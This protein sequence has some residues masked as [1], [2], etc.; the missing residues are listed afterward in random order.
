MDAVLQKLVLCGCQQVT[1]TCLTHVRDMHGLMYL[2]ITAT[3]IG[4]FGLAM[5]ADLPLLERL[6]FEP[7]PK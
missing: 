6:A 5:L 4:D 1:N 3:S 7:S 2:D